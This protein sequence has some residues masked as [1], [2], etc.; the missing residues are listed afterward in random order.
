MWSFVL[1]LGGWTAVLLWA[2]AQVGRSLSG[3][4]RGEASAE[5]QRAAGPRLDGGGQ[6]GPDDVITTV[7]HG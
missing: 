3:P 6:H 4:V 5:K 7:P 2:W 1:G